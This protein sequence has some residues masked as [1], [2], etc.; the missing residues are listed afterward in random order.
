MMRGVIAAPD[1]R[2]AQMIAAQAINERGVALY[3]SGDVAGC[4]DVYAN[5]VADLLSSS[6]GL[7]EN[8]RSVLAAGLDAAGASEGADARAWALRRALDTFIN[9]GG[10]QGPSA[11]PTI[12]TQ[13]PNV[14]QQPST[15]L[16]FAAA[17]PI[18]FRSV[19]DRVMGG[20]S[21]SVMVHSAELSAGVFSGELTAPF[22][23][24]YVQAGVNWNL[25]GA[26]K[27][28]VVAA[29]SKGGIFKLRLHDTNRANPAVHYQEFAV[30]GDGE[31]RTYELPLHLFRGTWRGRDKPGTSL[32]RGNVVAIGLMCAKMNVGGRENETGPFSLAVKTI[33]A[34]P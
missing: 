12:F 9:I 17:M 15:S 30:E 25:N 6:E 11:S 18:P 10:H 2:R 29:S 4:A 5:V 26:S 27:V 3:N 7:D 32:D 19:D 28:R 20:R 14:G 33:E 13:S 1:L 24:A 8:A 23:A 31:F 22:Y 21:Q 16:S 34:V